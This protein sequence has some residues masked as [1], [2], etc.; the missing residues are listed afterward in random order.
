MNDIRSSV[1]SPQKIWNRTFISIFAANGMMYLGMQM[2]NTLVAKYADCLGAS[3][4]VVGLVS[5]IYALSALLLKVVS[6]PA[7][8][9]FNRKWILMGAM[10]L[11][12]LSYIGLSL[13]KTVPM[14]LVFRIMQGCGQAFSATCCLAIASDALPP[15]KLSSGIGIFSMALAACQAIGPTIGLALRDKIGYSYTFAVAAACMMV[16]VILA[17]QVHQVHSNVRLFR[18]RFSSIVAKEALMP[19]MLQMLLSMAFAAINAFLVIYSD[20]QGISGVGYFFTVYAGTMLIS[21]PVIGKLNDQYGITKVII[22]A[23]GCFAAS[24]LLISVSTKLWMLLLAAFLSAFGYGASQPAVQALCMKC[25]PSE[26]RGA[27]SSTNY[28]GNDIGVFLGPVIGGTIIDGFA[29]EATGYG[30]MWRLMLIPVF[31]ALIFVLVFRRY[32]YHIEH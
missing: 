27:A 14:L 17:S 10:S 13:S 6:G 23:I 26:R 11:M 12:G 9:S 16:A 29:N 25:V 5:S 18:I 21:R 1:Q 20:I 31:A 32:I 22:P 3:T 8:D 30:W 2:I 28:I 24:F 19:G 4:T 15:E 7:I